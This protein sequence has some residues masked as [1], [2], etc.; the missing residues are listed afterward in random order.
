MRKIFAC[1]LENCI[2]CC[3]AVSS[4]D[5]EDAFPSRKLTLAPIG[6]DETLVKWTRAFR[7]RR[8]YPTKPQ[9][10]LEMAGTKTSNS[11]ALT[12]TAHDRRQLEDS[13]AFQAL[14]VEQRSTLLA[15]FDAVAPRRIISFL[16]PHGTPAV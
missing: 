6:H 1:N 2:D 10:S 9:I 3:K 16:A 15:L 5:G 13:Q 14:K 7:V 12:L 11:F 4:R 8:D